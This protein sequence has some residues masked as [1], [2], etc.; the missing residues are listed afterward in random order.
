MAILSSFRNTSE[1]IFP[2]KIFLLCLFKIFFKAGVLSKLEDQR[3]EKINSLV[4]KLQSNCRRYLAI[5]AYKK[6]KVSL[7][8]IL[9]FFSIIF[10]AKNIFDIFSCKMRPFDAYKKIFAYHSH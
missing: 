6:K 9:N 7:M 10:Q 3:D 4:I 5:K 1:V 2:M 8:I